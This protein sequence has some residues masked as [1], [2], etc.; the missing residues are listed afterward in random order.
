MHQIG[1]HKPNDYP[2]YPYNSDKPEGF[3]ANMYN[4]IYKRKHFSNEDNYPKYNI[5]ENID[6][7]TKETKRRAFRKA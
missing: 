1:I 3:Y 7:I 4:Y 2:I 5:Y 6:E